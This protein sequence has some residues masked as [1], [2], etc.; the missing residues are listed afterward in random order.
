MKSIIYKHLLIIPIIF[1]LFVNQAVGE[2]R[3]GDNFNVHTA[4][5]NK[6]NMLLAFPLSKQNNN[7]KQKGFKLPY[8]W[9]VSLEGF[10]YEQEYTA[11][12]L[13]LHTDVVKAYSD[14]LTQYISGGMSQ[15]VVR[16]EI[17]LLP[18]LDVYGIIGFAH[19]HLE[20]DITANGVNLEIPY[21]DTVYTLFIDT[22]IVISKPSRYNAIVYGFGVTASYSYS[23]FFVEVDYNYSEVHPK[24]MAGK[25]IS[26]RVSPKVGKMFKFKKRN[27][28]G[29]VWLG[30]SWLDD[31]QTLTGV[32][33]VRDVAGDLANYIGEKAVY[34][35]AVSPVN[36]WNMT[37]GGSYTL[38]YHFNFALEVGFIDRKKFAIGFMYR[39]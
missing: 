37:L 23:D 34:T 12:K 14:S 1:L 13:T 4:V 7:K 2:N 6:F 10:A 31:S 26:N 8:A 24:E 30:A 3:I 36:R 38:N 21:Q 17:W 22:N 11:N 19:G 28:A 35:A 29:S 15:V 5:K 27:Q 18:Y 16:P 39:L 25:L 20:P 33:N 9:G 32:V